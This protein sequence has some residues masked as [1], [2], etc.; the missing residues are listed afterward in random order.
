MTP[1]IQ[2]QIDAAVQ[3]LRNAGARSVYVFGSVLP[4]EALPGVPPRDID[5]AVE[6]LPPEVYLKT[7]GQL[8]GSLD[9]PVDLIDLDR[10]TRFTRRLRETGSLHRVA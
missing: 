5:L 7:V 8:S 1:E 3:I 4:E 9:L 6:G 2:K 10:P